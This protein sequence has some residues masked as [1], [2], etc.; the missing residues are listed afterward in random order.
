MRSPTRILLPLVVLAPV[1]AACG[2]P[3]TPPGPTHDIEVTYYAPPIAN[4]PAAF[5][6]AVTVFDPDAIAIASADGAP[7]PSLIEGRT[8]QLLGPVGLIDEDGELQL[9]LPPADEDLE[10]VLV[11]AAQ[12]LDYVIGDPLGCPVTVSDASV[13]VTPLAFDAI[14]VPGIA[15]LTG[16]GA[17]YGLLTTEELE[18]FDDSD[19]I[20]RL[21]YYGLV[22]ADAPLTVTATD[23]GCVTGE[24]LY[25]DLNLEAGWNWVK[26]SPVFDE[27]DTL[28][29]RTLEVIDEPPALLLTYVPAI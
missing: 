21:S 13:N 23:D 18:D 29:H 17:Y 15:P 4:A 10:A 19:A 5:G 9:D 16:H 3:T 26:W 28:T 1:L 12:L 8:G 11:P 25:A 22:Y 6:A 27:T 20:V 24:S 14:T 2:A 7:R